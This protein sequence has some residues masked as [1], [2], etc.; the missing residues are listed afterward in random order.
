MVSKKEEQDIQFLLWL[1][2]SIFLHILLLLI[3]LIF[4]FQSSIKDL[5]I[6]KHP[7]ATQRLTPEQL[8]QYKQQQELLQQLKKEEEE[9]KK[10]PILWKDLKKPKPQITYDLIPGRQAVTEEKKTPE[11]KEPPTQQKPKTIEEKKTDTEPTSK[12]DK[13]A[14]EKIKPPTDSK[15]KPVER[16]DPSPEQTQNHKKSPQEKEPF[17]KKSITQ[18]VQKPQQPIPL[19]SDKKGSIKKHTDIEQKQLPIPSPQENITPESSAPIIEQKPQKT[20]EQ[21]H[22]E[23]KNKLLQETEERYKQEEPFQLSEKMISQERQMNSTKNPTIVKQKVTLQDLKL[24]FAKYM[25]EGNNDILIQRGNTNQPP[26]AQA[27]RLITYDQQQGRTIVNAIAS[28]H[29]YKL[30]ENTRGTQLTFRITIDRSGKLLDLIFI[31]SSGNEILDKI[32]I[33]SLQ[34]IKLYPK[35]PEYIAGDTY[36]KLWT[37]LH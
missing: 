21:R 23:I 16:K 29:Q 28:H 9:K 34:G 5:F 32:V 13:A 36:S 10:A 17:Q 25:Q 4:Y 8:E 1:F 20:V 35:L 37:F 31:K 3:L 22:D 18:S 12:P 24:G 19:D 26:N 27:L 2:T 30:V 14:L 6:K 11:D 7:L 15:S 33:E